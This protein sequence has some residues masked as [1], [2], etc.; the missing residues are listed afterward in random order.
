MP[1]YRTM[2]EKDFL[3]AYMLQG[4]E[5]TLEI[6]RVKGGEVTGEG[7]KKTKKPLCFFK[8]KK[9]P[10]ALNVTNCRTVAAMYGVHTEQWIG[11]PITIYATTTEWAG[12]TVDCI[13]VR[14]GIPRGKANPAALDETTA[15]PVRDDEPYDGPP[16][17]VDLPDEPGS[18]G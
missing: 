10:L 9:K 1:D 7:G 6:E 15:P 8:G 13:R 17:H 12:K 3:Y 11:K 4:K 14:Q 16:D 2:F 5:H 18:D